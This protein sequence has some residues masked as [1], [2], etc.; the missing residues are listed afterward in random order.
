[1][2]DG[3]N[4]GRDRPFVEGLGALG[5]DA[6]EG[7][8]EGLVAQNVVLVGNGAAREENGVEA[9]RGFDLVRE[10]GDALGEVAAQG[11]ALISGSCRRGNVFGEGALA[12]AAVELDEA[13]DLARDADLGAPRGGLERRFVVRGGRGLAKIEDGR[14]LG[15]RV[16]DEREPAAADAAR[17]R[18]SHVEHE[19]GGDGRVDRG[20]PVRKGVQGRARRKLVVRGG[21]AMNRRR[22]RCVRAIRAR[23]REMAEKAETHRESRG[24][25]DGGEREEIERAI[26]DRAGRV[27]VAALR[28]TNLRD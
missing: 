14:L 3:G 2:D 6:H 20:T 16:V 23:V 26:I 25:R 21:R 13:R 15:G 8:A 24:R 9:G 5:A 27:A 22:R 19:G 10:R 18:R 7:A 12:P 11:K 1:M 28:S 4:L 17:H